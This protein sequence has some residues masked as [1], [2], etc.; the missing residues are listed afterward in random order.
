MLSF[1]YGSKSE[2]AV[3]YS[4]I[5]ETV[6]DDTEDRKI[7][8]FMSTVSLP[9]HDDDDE[10]YD[11]EPQADTKLMPP[12]SWLPPRSTGPGHIG[13]GGDVVKTEGALQT[14]AQA[15]EA[16]LTGNAEAQNLNTPLA[17]MLPP[18]LRKVDVTSLFPEFKPGQVLRFSR[19]FKPVHVP[20]LYR[21]R[22]R[23]KSPEEEATKDGVK[24]E[25]IV[26]EDEKTP[27]DE[28]MEQK[29]G[30]GVNSSGTVSEE[31]MGMTSTP[32]K[33]E[34]REGEE[35]DDEMEEEEEVVL[36]LNMGREALPEECMPDDELTMLES[37]EKTTASDN[38][39]PSG[40]NDQK[41]RVAPWRY[42]PAQLWY[43]MLG[44]D[45]T[46]E[47]FDYGF[48]LK[49]ERTDETEVKAEPESEEENP[50]TKIDFPDEA[51]QMVTQVQWEDDII[52][53]SEDAKQKVLQSQKLRAVA[54][55][56]IPSTN[57]RTATQFIQHARAQSGLGTRSTMK[58]GGFLK[59]SSDLKDGVWYS[60][61]PIENEALVY[62]NWEDD[63]IWDAENMDRIPSPKVLT[64]DPNDE[65]IILEIPEDRDPKQ[66]PEPAKKEKEVKKSKIL[67][68]KAGILKED[69]EKE[70]DDTSS[71][72]SKDPFNLSND[73][74][75]NP[76]L[77]TDTALRTNI[78][79][80][81]QHST[82]SLEL[83]QPFFPTH[84]GPMKLR[85]FHR[86]PLKKYSHGALSQAGPHPALPLLKQI[87]RKAKM[88]EQERQ[89]YGGGDMFFM[90]TPQDLTAM[91]GELILAEY[92][93]EYPPIMMQVGMA[94]KVK[95][96]YKRKPGKDNNPP[97]FNYGELAYAHTSPFLG[98]LYPGQCIQAFEN[99]MFRAP[100]F[101][102]D[103]PSTDFL[104]IR[105]RQHF[106]IREVNNIF[107]V[108]QLCPLYEVPGP[109]SKR[110]NNFI[111]DFLQVFIYRLFWKSKDNPRRIK[112]DD[113]KKAFPSH[114]ESSIRKRLK[115]CAD[116]K[117]TGMDSNWWVL[118]PD[119]R[120]PTEEEMR[121]MVSPEQC[122]AYYSMLAAEQR[123]KDAGYGEKSLFAPEDDNE[124]ETQMK[125]DDEVRTAPWNTTRAYISAMKGKCLLSLTGVADPTGCG[126]G[127]SYVKVP[128][129]PQPKEDNKDTPVKRTVTGTD[130]DLRRLNLRDAR[131][132]LKKF[133]VPE[134][135]IKKLSRWEVID[136]VRTMS[137]EQAKAGQEGMS[138]FARGNRFSV[139]EHQERYKE[140]CQRI[141]D[142]QNKVLSSN[143]VLSTDEDSSSGEDSEFEEMGKNIENMLANKKT[144][145]QLSLE[146]EEAERR[147]LQK[148]LMGEDTGKDKDKKG[149]KGG[150]PVKDDDALA[151]GGTGG[152]ILKITRTF[153]NESGKV[154]TRVEIVRKPVI[155]DTY[156]RIRQ[157]KDPNFIKQFA[158]LDEQQK[159]EM[160]RERRR[161]QEQLRR[162]K[163]NQER[164]KFAPPPPKKKKKKETP[165]VK[166]RQSQLKCGACGQIGHMR[167]N[168]ECPLYHRAGP[169][170]PVQ[171][172][173]TEEQE[174]EEEM[175]LP[176]END[177]MNIDGTKI[178]LSK[179]V[180]EHHEMI[181]RQSLVLK[182]PKQ[183]MET[184][185]RRRAGTVIHCDYLKRPSQSSNRR[186]TDPVVTLSSI[187]EG[188]LN[189][190]RDL[191]NTQPFL[192]PVNA[193][194]VPDY[195]K[196]VKE[197][198]DLQTLREG[199][200]SKKYR[201]REDFLLDVNRI[202]QNSKI[203]NGGKHL[204]T[205]AAQSM[206]DM[207][208][209]RFAEKE[210]KLMR[211]EKAIN[212]LLD[213]NDQVAFSFILETILTEKMK[214]V[215]NSWPFHQPV[216]KKFV[217]DYY[218][219][220]KQPMD[221]GTLLKNV[222]SHKY[223]TRE[224]FM[225][226]VELI[227]KNSAQY[228]GPD[229][230]LTQTA[231]RIVDVCRETLQENDETLTT[232]EKD[233]KAAQEAALDAVETD[234]VM[235]GTSLNYDDSFLGMD[236]E[237]LGS[238]SNANITINEGTADGT[239]E[240]DSFEQQ[241]S[242][243]ED[244][245]S[246]FVDVE[247]FDDNAMDM[248]FSQ[249]RRVSQ[250]LDS[251]GQ[252]ND[253]LAKDLQITPENTDNE[254]EDDDVLG[255]LSESGE[256]DMEEQ[257]ASEQMDFQS[258]VSNLSMDETSQDYNMT[259]E[260]SYYG[261][262]APRA[263]FSIP[264]PDQDD[265]QSFDPSD[266]FMNSSLAN[267][268]AAEANQ[269]QD[270]E[271]SNA[272]GGADIN[273]DLQVSESDEE[274]D[275]DMGAAGDNQSD[276]GFDIDEFLKA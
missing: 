259:D 41:M 27:K 161:L 13:A 114:S 240:K 120:L 220:I 204:I 59:E 249:R 78:G 37:V 255:K 20:H 221:L 109:N 17:A 116:F 174:E 51:F 218:T 46:G 143:E 251:S 244:V 137:T 193:K 87:K 36:K 92:S 165:S 26:K 134:S 225:A 245:E 132:F 169:T 65:N 273:N 235:T 141:F 82:P 147:E 157:T 30:E 136:V 69:E 2:T 272:V 102:H 252:D 72:Q 173:M 253:E 7:R 96:Y 54:A 202:V 247:A 118:K 267:Q 86:A 145:S 53:N 181:R 232:L 39:T 94:T 238:M 195:Y 71:V 256:S 106:F 254:K 110:A 274:S 223:H 91:D 260:Q 23:K 55:G 149:G 79:G 52:W 183:A 201:S 48:K 16:V 12:P 128:N 142:L 98:N 80:S 264:A 95:N 67:L 188:I 10:D 176:T 61:F 47:G 210:E 113:I 90:R 115:L 167:T 166:V 154:Y 3:D 45:E 19:L 197:P 233:I 258:A 156:V 261:S 119:F 77:T 194:A 200:R 213:D 84:M 216:N 214:T 4:D 18:E 170:A 34:V 211:L 29:G 185:R 105:T 123:L 237:S 236:N 68:G 38:Q 14:E 99:H 44:V 242:R 97:Q 93:E 138:K 269:L 168:K 43:D 203:Y 58:H 70:D 62:G 155:I 222:C 100:I 9:R 226:D 191:P 64:L 21:R 196:I 150:I 124:E 224:Q 101:E 107:T 25:K 108:G 257:D 187:F 239:G 182:F 125:I 88:R 179:R 241:S 63:I 275:N 228:N 5:T 148:M 229:G 1:D 122:C 127:F 104:I 76:K 177:L 171:V 180:V 159:E 133:G 73:E 6:E 22:K 121:A 153:M 152:K 11:Q 243:L 209:K 8:D 60:I 75:Y 112:M 265:E 57:F 28:S 144:S 227:Y 172:A 151:L 15:R 31:G 276:D 130:A 33:M 164:E 262:D 111:R 198:M 178:K 40:D 24:E 89:A 74:Y 205:L 207:C 131:G 199:L 246:D 140:E 217:K 190:M 129:K 175:A 49:S 126:E 32:I 117:R 189:E 146:K 268:A 42:G 271:D 219:C 135:E 186:R 263:P 231:K 230:A 234:S 103:L 56:W 50:D 192:F 85:N 248:T 206:L 184:K 162:I 35:A 163:R 250:Q 270:E 212:P 83:R 139:A 208:L 66:Q 160:K 81:L 266:F 158:T 215:E